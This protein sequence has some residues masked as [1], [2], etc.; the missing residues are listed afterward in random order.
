MN[1]REFLSKVSKAA[2]L[3]SLSQLSCISSKIDRPNIVLVYTDDLGYGD[4]S[5]YGAHRVQTPNIDR[6]A[7]EGIR[8]TSAYSTAATCTPSRY[9]LLTGEYAWRRQGT[10][11]APG[12]ASLIIPTDKATLPRMLHRAGYT[13]AV[14]GKWHLGLGHGKPDWN[15]ELSP[16]PLE[17]GFDYCFLIPA[18]GDRVPC[19]YVENHRVAGLDPADPITVSFAGPLAGVPTGRNFPEQLKVG[20]DDQ[21]SDTIVNGISRIGYMKG[22]ESA[23]WVDEDMADVLTEKAR[24]FIEK[25]R[26]TPFFLYFALH[27][28]HV[29]RVPHPRFVGTTDMGARGDAIVQADWCVGEIL[30]TLDTLNL[31]E[32][33]IFIFSSDNGP[34]LNDGYMDQAVE[35]VGDHQQT[36][37]LRGGKYSSFEAGTRVPF[38][39]RWPAKVEPGESSALISQVDLFAACATL[40]NHSL[41]PEEAPDSIDVLLAL[42]GQDKIGRAHLV[43]EAAGGFLSLRLNQWKY[44]APSKGAK[45]NATKGI[46]TGRDT[47]PQLYDVEKDI[48]ERENVAAE[49]PHVVRQ[50]QQLLEDIRQ[51]GERFVK[52][53]SH[54]DANM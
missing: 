43:Q 37:P 19:V 51:K 27:D 20:A 33:T 9:S 6:L 31:A 52:H 13:S 28:I 53:Q 12:D 17:I 30:R 24:S 36:G 26:T 49:N 25:N 32:N 46:E 7:R 15:G 41:K 1:R 38:L 21:H 35:R 2:I 14:I 45:Y 18:T 40:I 4:V 34:V 29:P 48:G 10:G 5:C 22:G 54:I 8:F 23:R 47:D 39:L 11:I 42:I 44:I 50:M 16:G 3:T